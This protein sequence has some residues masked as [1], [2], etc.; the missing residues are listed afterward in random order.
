MIQT[1]LNTIYLWS[2]LQKKQSHIIFIINIG[3]GLIA[4]CT[5][6]DLRLWK[7]VKDF[8]YLFMLQLSKA[9]R[10]FYLRDAI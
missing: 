6:S 10:E 8:S 3:Q 1:K 2:A 9:T 5:V 4:K 7:S